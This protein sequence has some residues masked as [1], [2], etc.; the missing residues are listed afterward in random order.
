[1]IRSGRALGAIVVVLA[2]LPFAAAAQ[3]ED[4]FSADVSGTAGFS[5]NPFSTVGNDTGS[6]VVT[7]D[8]APRY[9]LLTQR[10]TF[11]LSA[12]ANFQ[13]YLKDYGRNDS[14]SGAVDYQGRPSERVTTHARIDLSSSVLGAFNSYLPVAAGTGLIDPITGNGAGVAVGTGTGAGVG[15]TPGGV[16]AVPVTPVSSLVPVTDIG[17][18]GLR[19]RRRTARLSGDVGVGVSARDTLTFSGYAE[20]TRYNGL[21]VSDYEAYTGTVGYSR[22]VSDYFDVGLQG[23]ASS[24][25]YRFGQADSRSYSI[26]A[27][28]S[29]RLSPLWTA[30]GAL[31]VSFVDSD[32]AFSTRS[33]SLSG[34]LDLCRRGQFSVMCVEASRQVSPTGV[35]GSQYFSMIGLNW[36]R[37]LDE[38]QNLSLSANYSKIGGGSTRLTGGALPLQTDYAQAVAGYD[39]RIGQRLRLVASVNY[40]QLLGG[41]DANRPADF[42][43]QVGLSYRIGDPR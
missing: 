23:S 34:N 32:T 25:D 2:G 5:N 17:L 38:R 9:Q 10:S 21:Q 11:T 13:Q 37:R 16:V 28:A 29:G 8:V 27:T 31:G 42:G 6:A 24:F 15:T 33:T 20:A 40:R 36:S 12:D 22:R 7:V 43:G 19:N 18:F 1:M 4:R 41:S 3:T 26:Q 35:A 30:S 39:R 14:Y